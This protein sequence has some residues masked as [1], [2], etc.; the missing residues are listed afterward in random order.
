LAYFV[1]SFA[2]T[3]KLT[4]L[5]L[6]DDATMFHFTC[7][8]REDPNDHSV[9]LINGQLCIPG[10]LLRDMVF[11]PVINQVLTLIEQQIEKMTESIDALFLVGGAGSV[12]LKQ[13]IET[14][15]GSKIATI[16]RPADAGTATL[17]GAVQC[18]LLEKQLV[19]SVMA[20]RSYMINVKLPAER[21]DVLRRPEYVMN[22]YGSTAICENRVRYLL[23]KGT[24]LRKGQR[25]I[26]LFRKFSKNALDC[27]FAVTIFASDEDKLMRYADEGTI[28]ERCKWAIDLSSLPTFKQNASMYQSGGFYTDFEVGLEMDKTEV[29][30]VLLHDNQEWGWQWT[31][32]DNI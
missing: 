23:E 12:Y 24:I 16:S 10:K 7:F 6:D 8:N 2:E 1:H 13:R 21:E 19:S 5:G 20:P 32:I 15:F 26:S 25:S 29:R 30:G 28:G 27:I 3:E 11:D 18:G 9:G 14:Q 17:R 22:N 31:I 4:Y